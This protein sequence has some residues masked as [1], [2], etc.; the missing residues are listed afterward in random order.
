MLLQ[1]L[2]FPLLLLLLLLL[3]M[4]L[5]QV[6][7]TTQSPLHISPP[8]HTGALPDLRARESAAVQAGATARSHLDTLAAAKADA[9]A[10]AWTAY[11]NALMQLAEARD[12]LL[13]RVEADYNKQQAAL[14]S[15]LR[16]SRSAVGHVR[17]AL[18][19][20]T[21]ALSGVEDPVFRV[22]A[23]VSGFAS[24]PKANPAVRMA[25][26]H[27]PFLLRPPCGTCS[28]SQRC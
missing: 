1:P 7:L 9:E 11:N 22:H 25:H 17:T 21:A 6:S 26:H 14:Q 23:S 5:L 3:L 4:P 12:E 18:K 24:I 16:C 8:S 13:A 27:A 15:A 19:V 2:C 10:R 28:A 20:A